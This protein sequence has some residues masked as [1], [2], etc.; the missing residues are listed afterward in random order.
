MRSKLNAFMYSRPLTRAF[1][2]FLN[3]KNQMGFSQFRAILLKNT[4]E[5]PGGKGI[6]VRSKVYSLR[7]V[8]VPETRLGVSH[9]RNI[10]HVVIPVSVHVSK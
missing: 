6:S 4:L 9:G 2:Q 7:C 10:W 8:E 5:I 1:Q 3:R